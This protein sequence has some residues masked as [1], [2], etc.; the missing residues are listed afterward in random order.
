MGETRIRRGKKRNKAIWRLACDRPITRVDFTAAETPNPFGKTDCRREP[1][2]APMNKFNFDVPISVRP[3]IVIKIEFSEQ[4]KEIDLSHF[5]LLSP[6]LSSVN[7]S[8]AEN[9]SSRRSSRRFREVSRVLNNFFFSPHD[10]RSPYRVYS[11]CCTP[12][13]EFARRTVSR[14]LL[15]FYTKHNFDSFVVSHHIQ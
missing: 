3:N 10:S 12:R 13:D 6:S 4:I 15:N 2:R 14:M 1:S 11:F 8:Y 5:L 7:E 9:L